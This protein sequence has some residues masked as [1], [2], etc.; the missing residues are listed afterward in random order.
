[1]GTNAIPLNFFLSKNM[2]CSMGNMKCSTEE[3]LDWMI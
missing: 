2:K 3:E 1:M